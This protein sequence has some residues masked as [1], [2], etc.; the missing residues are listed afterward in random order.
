[1]KRDPT[2]KDCRRALRRLY[3]LALRDTITASKAAKLA[4]VVGI[5]LKSVENEEAR[6]STSG[7]QP[8]AQETARQIRAF[9]REGNGT[10]PGPP[11]EAE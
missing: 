9:L 8:S 5:I 3:N 7:S 1:M 4:Y 2:I 11:G 6:W 10:I